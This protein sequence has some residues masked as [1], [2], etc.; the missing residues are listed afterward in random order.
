[1]AVV[2]SPCQSCGA[3]C[4][5]FRV[6]F[7]PA[8][9]AG[10]AFAWGEGVPE[11]LTVPVTSAIVRMQGTDATEPRCLALVGEVGCS[12]SCSIYTERP[13]PCREFDIEHPACNRARQRHGLAPL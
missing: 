7:H 8:E 3:C 1:M 6:D 4:A 9:L 5:S 12:V 10:G 2:D 13:S 11:N